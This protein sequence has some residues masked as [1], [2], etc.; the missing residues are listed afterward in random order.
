MSAPIPENLDIRALRHPQESSRFAVAAVASV[1]AIVTVVV[2]TT[3]L[4]GGTAL[5]VLVGALAVLVATIWWIHQ[6]FRSKLFGNGALV[7]PQSF[8]VLADAI[9]TIRQKL[10]Y[11]RRIAVFVVAK[12][13][14]PWLVTSFFGTR[15]FVLEGGLVRQQHL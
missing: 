2:L 14:A 13:D 10:G 12:A 9:D 4:G 8:P 15:V 6:V 7:T 11:H 1:A 3:A 5:L